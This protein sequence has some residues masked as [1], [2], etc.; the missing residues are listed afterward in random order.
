MGS[1]APELRN[2]KI[3]PAAEG[4]VAGEA[5]FVWRGDQELVLNVRPIP[6]KLGIA[7]VL[8]HLLSGIVRLEVLPQPSVCRICQASTAWPGSC[9]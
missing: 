8:L 9:C 6:R 3:Q 5:D 1:K 2:I 4:R 7:T